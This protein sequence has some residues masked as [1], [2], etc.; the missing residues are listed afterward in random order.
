MH[1]FH[2]HSALRPCWECEHWGG[3]DSAGCHTVCLQ[4]FRITIKQGPENGC[5][6]WV[7]ATG[8]DDEDQ[9]PNRSLL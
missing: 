3:F 5:A 1:H 2:P 9:A 6:F 4:G 7:R 8:A